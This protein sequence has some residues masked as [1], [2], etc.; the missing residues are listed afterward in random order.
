MGSS[1]RNTVNGKHSAL[2][3]RKSHRYATSLYH[4]HHF[5]LCN[6]IRG[7]RQNFHLCFS[8]KNIQA[9]SCIVLMLFITLSQVSV[10]SIRV[11]TRKVFVRQQE[12]KVLH[13]TMPVTVGSAPACTLQVLNNT[14][15][16]PQMVPRNN[17]CD[18]ENW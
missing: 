7:I 16:P 15:S 10:G 4:I 9:L 11:K 5:T 13:C 1:R 8:H 18:S 3:L 14:D 2:K 12:G 6:V 17:L